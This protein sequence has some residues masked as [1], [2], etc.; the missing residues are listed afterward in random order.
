MG[1]STQLS[2]RYF[3]N[4]SPVLAACCHLAVDDFQVSRGSVLSV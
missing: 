4:G 3:S 1:S 2:E